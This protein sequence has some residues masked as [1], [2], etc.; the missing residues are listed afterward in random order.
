MI[1]DSTLFKYEL[2]IV[3]ILKNEA[4]YMKE[5]IDYHLIA[6]VEHFYLYDNESNDNL[7][8]VLKPYIDEGIVTLS[9]MPGKCTQL[10][11]YNNAIRDF[12]FLVRYMAFIDADEFI[13]PKNDKNIIEVLNEVLASDDNAEGLGVHWN[14]YG[15]SGH[16][17]ADLTK[18]VLERFTHR[19]F[20]DYYAH[21]STKSIANPRCIDVFKNPHM[22]IY[23]YD[24]Y[25]VNEDGKI[26]VNQ[27][28]QSKVANKI[29]LNH[30]QDES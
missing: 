22:P 11:A 6:G 15:S 29:V 3:A 2:A 17:K 9:F 10:L 19:G 5:W 27:V 7:K 14:T 28:D 23:F 26:M 12:K 1:E 8:E 30:Y 18:G 13:Y 25:S 16:E 4:P 20:D 21:Q 24:K